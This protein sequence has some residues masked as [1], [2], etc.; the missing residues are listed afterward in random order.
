MLGISKRIDYALLLLAA[1]AKSDLAKAKKKAR[2]FVSLK[3]VAKENKLPYKF[4]SQIAVD[5]SEAELLESREGSKGGYR[6]AKKAN[7]ISVSHVMDAVE[8]KSG[9]H[10]CVRGDDCQCGNFC[11][12]DEVMEP[13]SEAVKRVMGKRTIADLISD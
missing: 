5:L 10:V 3:A 9:D 2:Q 13:M 12:R 6:L 1:L 11:V 8:T 4:L 7:K